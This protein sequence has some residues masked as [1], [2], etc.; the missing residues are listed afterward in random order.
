M[1]LFEYI[2]V[3]SSIVIS[4]TVL[5]ILDALPAAA[6][7]ERRHWVHLGWLVWLLWACAT[8]WWASWSY[9]SAVWT[10]PRF[11]LFLSAPALLFGMV[12]TLVSPDGE[13]PASWREHFERVR[14]RFFALL[15][16]YF[17]ALTLMTWQ[18]LG[19]PLIAPIRIAHFGMIGAGAIGALSASHR[20]QT[21]VLLLALAMLAA[22]TAYGLA[23][24]A[25]LLSVPL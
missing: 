23:Q 7:P 12:R 19:I 25:P 5:R 15:C 20:V 11:L 17:V 10:Y 8:L 4:F 1:T 21:A 22:A 6:D 24:P 9:R 16:L 2:A 13:R 18:L 14:R 3:A